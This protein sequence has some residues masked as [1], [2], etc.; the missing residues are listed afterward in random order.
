M[1]GQKES[2]DVFTIDYLNSEYPSIESFKNR[3]SA[4]EDIGQGGQ[5]KIKMAIDL[6]AKE[7]VALKIF[8]K[9]KMNFSSL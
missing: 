7:H 5:A 1:K 3:F 2:S 8:K 4:I 9:S 6:L